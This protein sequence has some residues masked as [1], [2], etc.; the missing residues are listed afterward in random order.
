MPML[1]IYIC[2]YVHI[3]CE[4]FLLYTY[5]HL[6]SQQCTG[7]QYVR[8][9]HGQSIL[10]HF[11]MHDA[12][13]QQLKAVFIHSKCSCPMLSMC[14]C[15]LKRLLLVCYS[16]I[17]FQTEIIMRNDGHRCILPFNVSEAWLL[18]LSGNGSWMS[19]LSHQ[20]SG[21]VGIMMDH[22]LIPVGN[23]SCTHIYILHIYIYNIYVYYIYIYNIYIYVY[24][25]YIYNIYVY[26]IYI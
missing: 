9:A 24:Y 6:S 1:Y 8:I 15:Q 17:R 26:Y 18:S 10:R 5:T 16:Y 22:D 4:H 23:H 20:G 14:I 2:V 21:Y 25:I 19:P 3:L 11:W 12:N 13:W 7:S